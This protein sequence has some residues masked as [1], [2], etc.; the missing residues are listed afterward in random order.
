MQDTVYFN[1]LDLVLILLLA[2]FVYKGYRV[3]F[4]KEFVGLIGLLLAVTSGL[5]GVQFFA[6]RLFENSRLTFGASAVLAFLI[7]FA[8]IL[9]AY[10]YFERWIYKHAELKMTDK[11][12]Q[13]LGLLV[14][15]T[16]GLIVT[17]LVA[18][19]LALVPISDTVSNYVATSLFHPYFETAGPGIYNKARKFIPGAQEF[20]RYLENAVEAADQQQIE[21]RVIDVLID[22]N[23]KKVETWSDSKVKK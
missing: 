17:S 5:F 19:A 4:F 9:V 23:S 13:W 10:R 3:R 1:I 11:I 21:Q 7:L 18:L 6:P 12:D 22:L 16:K 14:G 2:A 15:L 8:F 20:V